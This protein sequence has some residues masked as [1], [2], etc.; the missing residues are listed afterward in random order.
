MPGKILS[1]QVGGKLPEGGYRSFTISQLFYIKSPKKKF[2]ANDISFGGKYPYVAR[3]SLN[4]GI[5][6]YVDLDP[7]YLNEANSLSFGQDTATIFYQEKPYFTG[8]K[9]KILLPRHGLLD[10]LTAGYIITAMRKSFQSFE[11]G[12][13]SFSEDVI[14]S[15]EVV[16]PCHKSGTPDFEFMRSRIRELEAYLKVC[17]FDDT[18]LTP[19]E[20][21]I[22]QKLKRKQIPFLEFRIVDI[23]NVR[24]SHNILKTSVV[25]GSGNTPYVTASEGNN[26]IVGYIDYDKTFLEQ[27]NVVF[28]GGK[29]LVITYQ[30]NEFFSNDSHNLLL[31]AK[32][33]SARTAN[34]QLFSVAAL[35]KAISNKYSWGNSISKAKI[36]S[37]I[38]S[39][40]VN[41]NGDVDYNT[42]NICISAIKKYIVGNLKQKIKIESD[43][44]RNIVSNY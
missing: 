43:T 7:C 18:T 21:S 2:N 1:P 36:Q 32:T 4:N 19:V 35:T 6:G 29:T 37:D 42:M 38:I 24:N 27:G 23:Y 5:R 13:T 8:D 44:Y 33:E 28:I 25:I 10:R 12:L 34:C 9:I 3:G 20:I 30:E 39:L 14:K 16:L 17:G 11:W 40:P 15:V 41:P 31:R 26:S 22:L